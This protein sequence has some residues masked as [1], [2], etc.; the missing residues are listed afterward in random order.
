M[1]YLCVGPDGGW[2]PIDE[3]PLPYDSTVIDKTVDPIKSNSNINS[4]D[5]SLNNVKNDQFMKPSISES[6]LSLHPKNLSIWK[7]KENIVPKVNIE[8]I[9]F[10]CDSV[11]A[12]DCKTEIKGNESFD[13][14]IDSYK[15]V[16]DDN[17][18]I[19]TKQHICDKENTDNNIVSQYSPSTELQLNNMEL[20]E[21]NDVFQ[22]NSVL[23]PESGEILVN[24]HLE[25]VDIKESTYLTICVQ[26][27]LLENFNNNVKDIDTKVNSSNSMYEIFDTNISINT[28]N[29]ILK[30]DQEE[31]TDF[32]D[33]ETAVP[34]SINVPLSNRTPLENDS[35]KKDGENVVEKTQLVDLP[36]TSDQVI[37]TQFKNVADKRTDS[38]NVNCSAIQNG[39]NDEINIDNNL[40]SEFNDFCDFHT[41]STSFNERRH[42]PVENNDD[43]CDFETSI[44]VSGD[45][46]ELKQSNSE[47]ITLFNRN[48]DEDNLKLK[49]N[50]KNNCEDDADV[51]D[52]FCDF[53]SGY[54]TTSHQFLDTKHKNKVLF[55]EPQIQF[56]YKQFCKD[57]FQGDFV[58]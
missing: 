35:Y 42:T 34:N 25:P 2:N 37:V 1:I 44:S 19:C 8:K 40:D 18:S 12:S 14:V 41:F 9:T 6:E 29:N 27:E 7:D 4:S 30:K 33:F 52:N 43:F 15:K 49:F 24:S 54:S 22:S 48:D 13:N 32:C 58:S 38:I 53:E 17:T 46:L 11:D 36:L 20:V 50:S 23:S 45:T 28:N 57:A 10:N 47:G 3:L 51:D 21:S 56:D 5:W 55:S 31:Y 39:K 26:N 16:V